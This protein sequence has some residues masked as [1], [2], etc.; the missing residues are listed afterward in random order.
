MQPTSSY[1]SIPAF[2]LERPIQPALL[3]TNPICTDMSKRR[4]RFCSSFTRWLTLGTAI[5]IAAFPA[6][7]QCP[8]P[9]SAG[10]ELPLGMA[11][12]NNGDLI[13]TESG[14]KTPNTGRVSV[15]N[16][17]GR[18][19]LLRG[20]PS[21]ISDASS[22]SGPAGLAISARTIYLAIGAGDSAIAGDTPGSIIENP[23]PSSPIF[24]SV[25]ALHFSR[26]LQ[27]TAGRFSLDFHDQKALAHG[28]K[29]KL[30]NHVGEELE[31]E[32]VAAFPDFL[33]DRNA[34]V[35][36][37]N[38]FG[39][40]A[41]ADHLYVTDGGENKIWQIDL[42]SGSFKTLTQF[43]SA[44]NPLYPGLGGAN[45][46][47]VPTGITFS[48]RGLLVTLFR[49]VPFAPNT[50]VAVRVDPV[51]GDAK[52][53]IAGL[54]S[55]IDIKP[56][57]NLLGTTD[58]L[59]LQFS[60]VGPF[61]GGPGLVLRF[62]SPDS[63]GTLITDHLSSPTSMTFDERTGTLYVTELGGDIVPIPVHP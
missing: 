26:E 49:G 7:S 52:E 4:A 12:L 13:V 39:M 6:M 8:L 37:S 15:V 56:V 24:S 9:F 11:R 14:S 32:L 54:T 18:R 35:A 55:A 33:P 27:N 46:D 48:E 31:I 43:P 40:V 25:L 30:L 22:P 20:L 2:I 45:E 57:R 34:S 58:Y 5:L 16:L 41:V 17:S 29:I 61:L 10:L 38:P 59:V 63:P 1:H 23:T 60:S 21:G 51:T 19:T 36:H 28:K 42:S 3:K 47:A 53:F 62:T 44:A 50:S